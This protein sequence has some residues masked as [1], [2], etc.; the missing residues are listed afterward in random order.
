MGECMQGAGQEGT[1]PPHVQIPLP[2]RAERCPRRGGEC[3]PTMISKVKPCR[4]S[5]SPSPLFCTLGARDRG[6]P[7]S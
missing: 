5:R 7:S 1:A 6:R 4:A 3:P 2:D